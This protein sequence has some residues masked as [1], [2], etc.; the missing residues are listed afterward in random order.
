[1]MGVQ[2]CIQNSRN[3]LQKGHPEEGPSSSHKR[4]LGKVAMEL[5]WYVVAEFYAANLITNIVCTI[6]LQFT[7]M[8]EAVVNNLKQISIIFPG[9]AD[10][11]HE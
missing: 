1:M 6:N 11:G 7:Q 5:V 2:N 10:A 4:V 8:V 3:L 9:G